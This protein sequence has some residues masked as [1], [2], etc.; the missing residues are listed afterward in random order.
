MPKS[1]N[2]I[3]REPTIVT[4]PFARLALSGIWTDLVTPWRVRSPVAV[5]STVAPSAGTEPR[6]IGWVSLNVAVGNCDV[7]R[8][9]AAELAVA[10]AGRRSGAWSG[11]R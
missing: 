11:R 7:S 10:V 3:G 6:S 5:A 1:A 9:L 2:W 8:R 4:T